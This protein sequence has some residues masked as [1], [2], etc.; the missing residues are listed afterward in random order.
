MIAF[1]CWLNDFV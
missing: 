1:A